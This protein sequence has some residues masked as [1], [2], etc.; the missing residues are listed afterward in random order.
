MTVKELKNFI[1]DLPDETE[2]EVA[3]ENTVEVA[4][5]KYEMLFSGGKYNHI[6]LIM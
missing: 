2:V 1:K 4:T 5:C 3:R 6:L